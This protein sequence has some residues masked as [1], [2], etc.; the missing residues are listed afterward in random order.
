VGA[1]HRGSR[2]IVLENNS[3][4]ICRNIIMRGE[5]LEFT[6]LRFTDFHYNR[7]YSQ[8]HSHAPEFIRRECEALG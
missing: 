7:V 3:V 1:T 8:I 2:R 6:E 4:N 5:F